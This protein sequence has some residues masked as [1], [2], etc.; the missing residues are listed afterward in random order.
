MISCRTVNFYFPVCLTCRRFLTTKPGNNIFIKVHK[1]EP[2]SYKLRH[3]F[4]LLCQFFYKKIHSLIAQ[5]LTLM[6]L[7][8]SHRLFL[9][10]RTMVLLQ[11]RDSFLS[12][13]MPEK[14]WEINLSLPSTLLTTTSPVR[15]FMNPHHFG[16]SFLSPLQQCRLLS[17][18]K[19][20]SRGNAILKFE[21]HI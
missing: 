17:K 21:G 2:I 15:S 14:N 9:Q 18:T 13:T 20:P 5:D 10:N 1:S 6:F 16:T 12:G 8:F 4:L 19:G 11:L 7:K 3:D